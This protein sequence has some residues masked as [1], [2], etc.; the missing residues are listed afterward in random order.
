MQ[1]AGDL[2]KTKWPQ[3][4][5]PLP[6]LRGPWSPQVGPLEPARLHLPTAQPVPGCSLGSLLPSRV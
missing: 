1:P 6:V 5:K 3:L 2:R 4:S